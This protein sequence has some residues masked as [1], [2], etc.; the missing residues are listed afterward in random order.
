MHQPLEMGDPISENQYAATDGAFL[1]FSGTSS[2]AGTANYALG[3]FSTV[4]AGR[5]NVVSSSS[6]NGFVGG[7]ISNSV[8]GASSVISGG[9]GNTAFAA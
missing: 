3:P 6:T 1:G 8:G 9:D 2:G 7:G 4:V 5:N